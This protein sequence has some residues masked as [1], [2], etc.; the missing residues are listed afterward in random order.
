VLRSRPIDFK[1]SKKNIEREKLVKKYIY[2][3]NADKKVGPTVAKPTPKQAPVKSAETLSNLEMFRTRDINECYNYFLNQTNVTDDVNNSLHL[4][5][6]L[7]DGDIQPELP[8]LTRVVIGYLCRGLLLSKEKEHE[9]A[10]S[11]FE[12]LISIL[13]EER[14]SIP[15]ALL[16][17]TYACQAF[18]MYNL[19]EKNPEAATDYEQTLNKAIG[20]APDLIKARYYRIVSVNRKNLDQS[21]ED[22]EQVIKSKDPFFLPHGHYHRGVLRLVK[23]T[24]MK[25]LENE[26]IEDAKVIMK[27]AYQESLRDF[28]SAIRLKPDMLDAYREASSVFVTMHDYSNGV[29]YQTEY[30]DR[31]RQLDQPIGTALFTRAMLQLKAGDQENGYKDLNESFTLEPQLVQVY[32]SMVQ[33]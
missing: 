4:S 13:E 31:L 11:D 9:L 21:L 33:V 10:V 19:L 20:L 6:Q 26:K 27:Q 14:E 8:A 30:I 16:G 3:D 25:R 29:K 32:A 18:S 15:D 23:E 2:G 22:C 28:M 1:P 5:T 12:Q 24:N 7:I 17:M